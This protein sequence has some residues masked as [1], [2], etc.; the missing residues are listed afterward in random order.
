MI[1]IS[2]ISFLKFSGAALN[3]AGSKNRIPVDRSDEKWSIPHWMYRAEHFP[4]A[5]SGSGYLF[6]ISTAQCLF[7]NSNRVSLIVLEDVYVTGFLA[8]KCQMTVK[9]SQ[10]F[11][12]M[13]I[14]D[15][16]DV[17]PYKDVVIHRVDIEKMHERIMGVPVLK[18]GNPFK[19]PMCLEHL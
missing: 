1:Q 18:D 15:Y 10:S 5:V 2:Q 8:K 12:Y 6:P 14:K 7:K 19:E 11:K 17:N 16:C 13:G 4:M 3:S 9:N